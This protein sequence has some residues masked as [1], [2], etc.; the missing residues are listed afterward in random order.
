MK[1]GLKKATE[2]MSEATTDRPRAGDDGTGA[3]KPRRAGG[4][5]PALAQ[6]RAGMSDR[7]L[8]RNTFISQRHGCVYLGNPKVASSSVKW[9]LLQGE[10]AAPDDKGAARDGGIHRLARKTLTRRPGAAARALLDAGLLRFCIVRHPVERL[11]SAW[12]N[13]LSRP[14][15]R[16]G[17]IAALGESDDRPVSLEEFVD[18]VAAQPDP[19]RDPHWRSQTGLL[20]PKLIA[21]DHVLR[22]ETLDDDWKKLAAACGLPARLPRLNARRTSRPEAPPSEAM[23]RRIAG[24]YPEDMENFGYDV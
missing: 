4:K 7:D 12:H 5:N 23:R 9:V 2:P 14:E 20:F 18:H 16:A 17:V 11:V 13:K 21:Y 8:R 22:L 24:I 10:G 19:E 6:L 3:P 15:Y 1:P